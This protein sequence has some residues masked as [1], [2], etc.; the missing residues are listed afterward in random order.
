M[1]LFC[2]GFVVKGN[3]EEGALDFFAPA[4]RRELGFVPPLM[5]TAVTYYYGRVMSN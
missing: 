4:E 3:L 1:S 2:V 5:F